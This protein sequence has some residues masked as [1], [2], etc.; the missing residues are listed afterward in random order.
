MTVYTH[1]RSGKLVNDVF[2]LRHAISHDDVIFGVDF[3]FIYELCV[4]YT[5]LLHI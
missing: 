1:K 5:N 3:R 4:F 2:H